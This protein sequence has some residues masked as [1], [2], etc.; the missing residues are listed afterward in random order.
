MQWAGR[1]AEPSQQARIGPG[2][3]ASLGPINWLLWR[4]LSRVAGTRDA[5]LFSTL[6]QQKKLFRAWLRFSA[7][8]MPGG[9]IG[10]HDTELVILRV[11]HLRQCDYELDHHVRIGKRVGIDQAIA[12]R[13]FAGPT[14]PG[15]SDKHRALLH[16]VDALVA[17]K[18]IDN[19][20][21]EALRRHFSQAQTIEL[22][23]L[24]G[25]YEM[26]ATTIATLRIPRDF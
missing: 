5:H 18:D 1:V 10:R 21:F 8:L 12:A 17:D 20:R 13:V 9:Q 24:V 4:L 25:Q 11:A 7:Q 23:L 6:G 3:L 19:A 14:A 16:A 2:T 22:C 26:L 15:W